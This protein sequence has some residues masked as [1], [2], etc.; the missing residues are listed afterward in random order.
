M[1]KLRTVLVT[2]ASAGIGRAIARQLVMQG[3]RV[4]GVSRSVAKFTQA[5]TNFSGFE[6]DFA[7]LAG[8]PAKLKALAA[9]LPDLDTVVLA[10][11]YGQ[12]GN[13]EQFSYRQ[14]EQLMAVNFTGQAMLMRAL[15]PALKQQAR[16]DLVII[17][18]EA[19]LKGARKGAVYCAGKFALRGFA[20]A[21]REECGKSGLRVCLINPGMVK[22][23]FFDVLDFEPGDDP[24]NFLTPEDIAQ[25]VDYVLSANPAIVIDELNLN[26]LNKV[27]RFKKT[28]R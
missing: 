18:S 5:K 4:V 23:G 1:P 10:A 25:A 16:S 17:G 28:E 20:Q 7:D 22:T 21:L 3:H 24:T 6:L 26:P 8:L 9:L 27:I 12:F 15:L 13:L 19:G 11:G 14:I 2:G